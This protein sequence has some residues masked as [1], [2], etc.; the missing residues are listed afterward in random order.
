[1]EKGTYD[2]LEL[3]VFVSIRSTGNIVFAGMTAPSKSSRENVRPTTSTSP[4]I[5]ILGNLCSRRQVHEM[6]SQ[7]AWPWMHGEKRT[8]LSSLTSPTLPDLLMLATALATRLL[9][10]SQV[11][12]R[13]TKRLSM[14]VR[15]G[16]RLQDLAP[17]SR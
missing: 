2:I 16:M 3:G 13:V 9:G 14:F 12:Q 17:P 5:L 15:P 8:G 7:T 10:P 4:R 6:P 11:Q 1:M